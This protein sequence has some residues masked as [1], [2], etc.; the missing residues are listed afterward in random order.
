MPKSA[1][2]YLRVV[3]ENASPRGSGFSHPKYAMGY[4]QNFYDTGKIPWFPNDGRTFKLY[5]HTPLSKYN[6]D[7]MRAI[8]PGFVAILSIRPL[9][10]IVVSYVD[11]IERRGFGAIDPRVEESVEGYRFYSSFSA[12]EKYHYIINF[13][14]PW[15]SRFM[16]SWLNW[17]DRDR[18]RI[19]KYEDIANRTRNVVEDIGTFANH[20]GVNLNLNSDVNLD[21]SVRFNQGKS[22]RGAEKLSPSHIARLAEQ[23]QILEKYPDGEDI[24]RY[25]IKGNS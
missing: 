1:S 24:S 9:P 3:L 10:D 25:L 6:H 14:M 5:G 15:Y 20:W 18:L 4:G 23:V 12:D 21:V 19:V 13:V 7:I 8:D 16:A 11:D 17:A 22:G 2:S